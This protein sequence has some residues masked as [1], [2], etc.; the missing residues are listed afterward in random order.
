M[1]ERHLR[2][3]KNHVIATLSSCHPDFPP[4]FWDCLL[5]H[6]ELTLNHLR[7]FTPDPTKSAWTGIYRTPF[8][9]AAHPIHPPGQL[10]VTFDPPDS[11]PTWSRHGLRAF[12]LGPALDH[13][14]CHHVYV[15]S[16]RRP[17]ISNT[18]HHFPLPLFHFE[19]PTPSLPNPI[20]LSREDPTH[21][22]ATDG[23][24]LLGRQ[25]FDAEL[26]QCTVSAVALPYYLAPDEGNHS[27]DSPLLPPGWHNQLSYTSPTGA[28]HTSSVTEITAWLATAPPTHTPTPA[29]TPALPRRNPP[30]AAAAHATVSPPTSQPTSSAGA[31][32][33]VV[34][35]LVVRVTPPYLTRHGLP[36]LTQT[37]CSQR[38]TP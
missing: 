22:P 19:D 25:F 4:D 38:M 11:R 12:Y 16:T 23:T 26:G 10:V 5:P 29:P 24:D 14:R 17:R 27:P 21:T 32:S 2:T 30:R 33:P 8:D 1:A 15:V 3:A 9:F 34:E 18:L 7:P 28:I 31:P 37:S 35:V 13:Y 20:S 6:A 36:F